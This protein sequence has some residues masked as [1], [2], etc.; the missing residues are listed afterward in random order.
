[1][2]ASDEINLLCES[3]HAVFPDLH[4]TSTISECMLH[5]LGICVRVNTDAAWTRRFEIFRIN[6]TSNED[7]MVS[8]QSLGSLSQVFHDIASEVFHSQIR[9]HIQKIQEV[10]GE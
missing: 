7:P 3:L 6:K 2:K 5:G 9:D 10:W 8:K 4:M 1:M